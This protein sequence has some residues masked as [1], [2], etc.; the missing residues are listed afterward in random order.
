M[1]EYLE[2][3]EVDDDRLRSAP[4]RLPVQ[5]VNRPHPDFRGF[6]GMLV[7]GSVRPG[8]P[9]VV[10]PS[11]RQSVVEQIVSSDGFVAGKTVTL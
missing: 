6:S 8:D 3:V 9:I 1:L 11:G 2:S 10:K 4:L 7:S 5:W